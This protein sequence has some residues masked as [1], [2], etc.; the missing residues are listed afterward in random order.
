MA[1]YLNDTCYSTCPDQYYGDTINGIT[2]LENK[3]VPCD[4]KCRKCTNDPLPCQACNPTY[5]LYQNVCGTSC[6]TGYFADDPT[7][8]CLDC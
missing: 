1:Y 7:W 8:S 4:Y 2:G 6:P 3:C 5:Y